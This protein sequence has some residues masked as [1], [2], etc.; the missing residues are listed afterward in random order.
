MTYKVNGTTLTTQPESG[1]WKERD[2]IGKDGNGRP[3][4]ASP[5]EFE[6]KWGLVSM[7]DWAQL[8]TFF[9]SVGATGTVVVE[10]PQYGASSWTFYAYSGCI[11]SEPQLGVFFE[12]YISDARLIV[13]KITT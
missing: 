1:E 6:M 3:I 7:S 2:E 5:R 13:S 8:R 4:Y 10:L 11:L 12:E 9:Q